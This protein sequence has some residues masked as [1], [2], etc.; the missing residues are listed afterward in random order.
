MEQEERSGDQLREL[1]SI[2]NPRKFYFRNESW[3][4]FEGRYD[5]TSISDLQD[6]LINKGVHPSPTR[7]G[8]KKQ[9]K[10]LFMEEKSFREE[11]VTSSSPMN[12]E[13]AVKRIHSLKDILGM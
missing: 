12:K 6:I 13:L 9:V 5:V 3:E 8:L 11:P 4:Q 2:L 10:K 7:R 1:N